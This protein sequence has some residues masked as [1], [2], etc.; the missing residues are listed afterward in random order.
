VTLCIHELD[1]RDCMACHASS[2]D[3][4]R[5]EGRLAADVARATGLTFRQLDY[6]AR[7][8]FVRPSLEDA[9]G[10]GSWRRYSDDDVLVL[11][12]VKRLLDIGVSLQRIRSAMHYLRQP[13]GRWLYIGVEVTGTTDDLRYAVGTGDARVIIDLGEGV[14]A[15]PLAV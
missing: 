4:R 15:T 12:R 1:E 10:S 2:Y 8:N 9:H 14:Y 5:G 7:T 13:E 6:W 3:P 11:C